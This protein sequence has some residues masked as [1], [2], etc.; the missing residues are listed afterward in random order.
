MRGRRFATRENIANDVRQQVTRFTHG[1]ANAEAGGIQSLPHHWQRE[2]T[3]I[4][5]FFR[6]SRREKE[7]HINALQ[8]L[9]EVIHW[10][11][12]TVRELGHPVAPTDGEQV[13]NACCK[14]NNCLPGKPY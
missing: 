9:N 13:A 4:L 3:V 14:R 11:P 10:S 5:R 7:K 8:S 2:V 6:T 1:A 12:S